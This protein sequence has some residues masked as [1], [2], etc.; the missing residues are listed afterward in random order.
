MTIKNFIPFTGIFTYP[1]GVLLF[2]MILMAF[3]TAFVL[4]RPA[5]LF[6]VYGIPIIF[7]VIITLT[8]IERKQRGQTDFSFSEVYGLSNKDEKHSKAYFDAAYADVPERYASKIP[9][10][11][12]IGKHKGKYV[13]VPVMKDGINCIVVGTPGAGKSVMLL[14]FI[15]S[16]MFSDEISKKGKTIANR[17]YNYYM[18]DIKG[19]LYEKILGI[20]SKDYYAEKYTDL[21]V[22][23]PSNRNSYGWDIFYRVRKENVTDTEIIKTVSDITDALIME[24]NGNDTYFVENAKKILSGVL[25][26][27]IKHGIEFLEIMQILMRTSLDKLLTEIVE[28]AREKMMGVVIDKLAGFVGKGDNNSVGDIEVTLKTYLEIFSY[29]DI[30]Y[31]L[32][33]NPNKTSPAALDDGKTN[34]DI[35]IEEGMLGVYQP[36]FRL[37]SM[38]ILRH[39]ES[40]FHEDDDRYTILYLDEAS[41][42][43]R[44][45]GLDSAFATLRSKHTAIALFF[46]SISQFKDIYPE[47]KANTLLNLCEAKIFLSGSGDRD[48]TEYVKAMAGDYDAVKMSYKHKGFFGGKSDGTYSPEKRPIVDAR[49]LMDLRDKDEAI[50]FIYGKYVRC[51]KIKYYQDP[52]IAPILERRQEEIKNKQIERR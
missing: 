20:K 38:Q 18:V 10:G 17:K 9:T 33:D 43:G 32:N 52:Y 35:A 3:E 30:A 8:N 47:Q 23:Q 37:I 15:Y 4:P 22:V 11:L 19:E 41:R 6:V 29:P 27:Y 48:T 13:Y 36:L 45:N 2:R 34:L 39:C 49:T 14:S 1:I 7:P 51:K 40:N 26:Y 12:V 24:G 50:A 5:Q 42:I 25:Y 16:M 44:I 21:Q 28:D 31:C 46:Q